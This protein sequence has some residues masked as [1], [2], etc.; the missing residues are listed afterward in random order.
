MS[1]SDTEIC[2]NV[3]TCRVWNFIS[4]YEHIG[5]FSLIQMGS[6]LDDNDD[7][8]ITSIS[9]FG[10]YWVQCWVKPQLEHLYNKIDLNSKAQIVGLSKTH[11][12]WCSSSADVWI[13]SSMMKKQLQ[14]ASWSEQTQLLYTDHVLLYYLAIPFWA[15]WI[16]QSNSNSALA[17]MK[18]N[19]LALL[20]KSSWK[21]RQRIMKWRAEPVFL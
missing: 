2:R 18:L 1:V 20:Q 13:S 11:V 14:I 8:L 4:A 16:E 6:N 15:P 10:F 17:D 7:V 5:H 19:S 9:N 21:G 12:K 3:W